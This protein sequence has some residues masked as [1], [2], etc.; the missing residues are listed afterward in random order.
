MLL[1]LLM[2]DFIF[3]VVCI[4]KKDGCRV[5]TAQVPTIINFFVLLMIIMCG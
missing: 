5:T 2:M 3:V 1:L 4:N